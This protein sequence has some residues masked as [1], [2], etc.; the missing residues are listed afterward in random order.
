MSSIPVSYYW[1]GTVF[2]SQAIQFT[3]STQCLR[4]K[5]AN[6][7]RNGAHISSVL[8]FDSLDRVSRVE[9][10]ENARKEQRLNLVLENGNRV[11]IN[12][13]KESDIA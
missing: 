13:Y 7:Q 6:L 11:M 2:P 3:I 9:V 4:E 12:N 1:E 10:W 8:P 5:I